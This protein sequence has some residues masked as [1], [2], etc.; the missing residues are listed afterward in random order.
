VTVIAVIAIVF[1]GLVV[2]CCTPLGLVQFLGAASNANPAV[3]AIKAQP[4]LFAW[5]IF[6]QI[7]G[8]VLGVLSIAGGIGALGLKGW[9][10]LLLMA[11][12]VL[13][14]LLNL[15]GLVVSAVTMLPIIRS[16]GSGPEAKG[17]M[18]GVVFAS[19]FVLAI[20]AYKVAVLVVMTRPD[21]KAAFGA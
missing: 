15:V 10:R 16:M 17:M 7:A 6:Q 11:E 8:F 3:A 14:I 12:A 1:G 21:A 13:Y 19:C 9:A 20:L 18:F 2:L 5:T 4:L